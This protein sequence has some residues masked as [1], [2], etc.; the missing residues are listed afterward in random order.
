MGGEV[1]DPSPGQGAARDSL[2]HRLS[3]GPCAE[4]RSRSPGSAPSRRP[5]R[6]HLV[7]ALGQR[8][9]GAQRGEVGTAMQ[10]DAE[11]GETSRAARHA[12]APA[13]RAGTGQVLPSAG[14][15]LL[16]PWLVAVEH[17]LPMAR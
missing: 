11:A 15:L 6:A 10:Q 17:G 12:L 14:P 1:H 3:S 16:P 7:G 9:L 5:N 4:Q 8:R 2:I 13:L